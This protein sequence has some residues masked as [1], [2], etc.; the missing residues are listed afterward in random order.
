MTNMQKMNNF[1]MSTQNVTNLRV[2]SSD[3]RESK[4]INTDE[5]ERKGLSL[6]HFL[7][8]TANQKLFI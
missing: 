2:Y 3:N 6:T 1:E 7:R 5:S 8:I 4:G